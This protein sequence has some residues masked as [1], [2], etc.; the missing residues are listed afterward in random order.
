MNDHDSRREAVDEFADALIETELEVGRQEETREEAKRHVLF[1]AVRIA[2]GLA[3]CAAGVFLIVF[4]GPGMVVLAAGLAILSRDVP[5]ARRLLH[6]VRS[7][8]PENDRGE[9]SRPIL[10]G[11]LLL[12][13]VTV[14]ASLWW[15]LLR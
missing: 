15:W 4:P 7:R 13:T 9:I 11:G 3:V 14:G 5:F 12:S 1:R 8:I 2:L 10:I 6:N